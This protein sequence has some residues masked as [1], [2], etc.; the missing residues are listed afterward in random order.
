[1]QKKIQR[2]GYDV[3]WVPDFYLYAVEG[4]SVYIR[5]LPLNATAEQV[6]EEFKKFGT[7]KPGGVQVRNHKVCQMYLEI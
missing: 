5:N 2:F 4:H 3:L 1:M 6:E 7:I